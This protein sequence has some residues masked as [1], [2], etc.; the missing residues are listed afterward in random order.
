MKDFPK[1]EW[2]THCSIQGDVHKVIQI[3]KE[4]ELPVIMDE[5]GYEGNIPFGWGNLSAF[6]EVHRAWQAAAYGGYVTHGETYYRDDEVLWW[7]K[8]GKLYGESAAR[9]AFLKSVL[10]EIGRLDLVVAKSDLAM[11]QNQSPP[12]PVHAHI[13]AVLSQLPEST[14][15][16][17]LCL[18]WARIGIIA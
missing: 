15:V 10:Y 17:C 14:E 9:F 4:Y 5:F 18:W 8:G 16:G 13:N 2:M 6:E 12:N 11:A 1:V 7:S 3:R